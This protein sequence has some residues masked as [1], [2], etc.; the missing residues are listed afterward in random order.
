MDVSRRGFFDDDMTRLEL[1]LVDRATG[2]PLWVKIVERKADPRDAEAVR[3]LL[4][5][6][7]DQP[8]GWEPAEPAP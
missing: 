5:D 2:R 1:T 6:A 3:K 7:L 8:G 4:D